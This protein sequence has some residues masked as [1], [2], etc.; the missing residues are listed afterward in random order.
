MFLSPP[1]YLKPVVDVVERD[2]EGAPIP[3]GIFSQMLCC[4]GPQQHWWDEQLFWL[5]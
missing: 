2:S 4:P 1:V 5:Y 3:I